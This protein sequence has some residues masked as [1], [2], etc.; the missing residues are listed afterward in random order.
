M[1]AKN[2]DYDGFNNIVIDH[3]PGGPG[4]PDNKLLIMT[5][6]LGYLKRISGKT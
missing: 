2:H 1:Y 3:F 6:Y 5:D 4:F